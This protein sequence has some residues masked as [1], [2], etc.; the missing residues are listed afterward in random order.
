[1][2]LHGVVRYDSMPM[3]RAYFTPEGYLKD[4][5]ILTSCGIFEYTNPDGSVRRE[6]RLPEDV[7][8]PES[9]RSYIGKPVVLTHEAGLIDKNNVAENQIGTILSEGERSGN[10]VKAEI[11]IHDTDAMKSA[12]LK[13]LSLGYNL[14]LDETPGVWNGQRYDAVQK[15][16]RINHLA[17]VR[18]A[19]A[20]EQARLNLDSRDQVNLLKGGKRMSKKT[21][22]VPHADA[23]LTDEELDKALEEY[24]KKYG[25][26]EPA[27]QTDADDEEVV[28]TEEVV[29]QPAPSDDVEATVEAVKARRD[30]RD[31]E[32][33]PEDVDA[34]MGMIA[35]QDEDIQTLIDLVDT[36]RARLDMTKAANSD[37][38]EEV[39]AEEEPTEEVPEEEVQAD[40]VDDL[41]TLKGNEDA[42]DVVEEEIPE[43][44]E[45]ELVT[46]A[47]EEEEVIPEDEENL[48]A[49]DTVDEEEEE[50]L[51]AEDG[52]DCEDYTG[53]RMNADSVER[54][55][56]MKIALGE[57]G[58][59]VG[60]KGLARKPVR[61]AKVAII[62]AAGLKTRMDGKSDVYVNE[63]FKAARDI[64]KSRSRKTTADQKRQMYNKKTAH[65]DSVDGG[66]A[67]EARERM[68]A[69]YN[70]DR[71]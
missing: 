63:A 14:D 32:G 56:N 53:K 37:E 64:I 65:M 46:D 49:D 31:E 42:D 11:I 71:K 39:P 68:I 58:D 28:K 51:F 52:E 67:F 19:R 15:N 61:D 66:S 4:R 33:D 34:A 40:E 25:K 5:P 2:I 13:E 54:L 50:D 18:E 62:R 1:M 6:L 17:L 55:V 27:A 12:G 26:T 36:L 57:L 69:K 38:E 3:P 47:D 48:D 23:V 45:E 9:L 60:I 20:G 43:D 22:R 59:R 8:S 24:D 16:I 44:E 29:E 21:K 35:H 70:K 7:F 41:E 30:K 10:D